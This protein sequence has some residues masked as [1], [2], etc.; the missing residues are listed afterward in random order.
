MEREKQREID[1][2]ENGQRRMNKNGGGRDGKIV[3]VK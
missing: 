2:G 1:V 3:G